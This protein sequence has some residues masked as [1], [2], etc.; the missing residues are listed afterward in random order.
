M[1]IDIPVWPPVIAA[2]HV[3][4]H[5]TP[6]RVDLSTLTDAQRAEA[7]GQI[8][9]NNPALAELLTDPLFQQLR[10]TFGGAVRVIATDIEG[11]P[12]GED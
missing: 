10:R 9:A 8:Q 12:R 6:A 1:D 5:E 3:R 2:G 4:D 11:A 7:W